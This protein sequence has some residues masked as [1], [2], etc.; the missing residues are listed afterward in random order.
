MQGNLFE[1]AYHKNEQEKPLQKEELTWK[2]LLSVEKEQEYF[3]KVITFVNAERAC[4][5][6]IYPKSEDIFTALT[7]TSFQ[8]VRVVIIGQDPYHGPNQAHGLCFSV[9]PGVQPPPSLLNIYQEI[10]NDLSIPALSLPA[11]LPAALPG[12][13]ESWARQGVLLLNAVLTVEA[14]KPQSHKGIG[15]ERFTDKVVSVLNERKKGLVF[16]LWGADAQR[17]GAVVDTTKHFVLKAPHPSP[18]SAHRGFFGCKHFSQT[19]QLLKR[20]GFPEIDWKLV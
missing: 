18:L 3:R 11:A 1:Q 4:G 19:N 17:K 12:C 14:S 6:T 15:W 13:L 7:M 5:K 9:L 8:K 20:Q 16:L 2:D 10:R